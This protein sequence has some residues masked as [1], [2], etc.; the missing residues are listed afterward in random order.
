MF[1]PSRGSPNCFIDLLVALSKGEMGSFSTVAGV[2]ENSRSGKQLIAMATST[3]AS[4]GRTLGLFFYILVGMVIIDSSSAIAS[5]HWG[6][7]V[8]THSR[9]CN[10]TT[11]LPR[12]FHCLFGLGSGLPVEPDYHA[13]SPDYISPFYLFSGNY[14]VYFL[15]RGFQ[16]IFLA[17][18]FSVIFRNLHHSFVPLVA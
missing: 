13:V 1:S 5:R 16:Q 11:L 10:V 4:M 15:H 9:T 7:V 17:K 6:Y 8:L 3:V 18:L 12:P 14:F 2:P